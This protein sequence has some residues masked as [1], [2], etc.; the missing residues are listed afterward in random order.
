MPT[1]IFACPVCSESII[2][3]YN[4]GG[5]GFAITVKGEPGELLEERMAKSESAVEPNATHGET[6]AVT[7]VVVVRRQ[8]ND[9]RELEC[10]R[11][12][13]TGLHWD[14]IG[15]GVGARAPRPFL[16]GYISCDRIPDGSDFPHSCQHGAG[17]HRIKVVVVKKDN[18]RTMF[19]ALAAAAE[20]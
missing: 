13:I 20:Y 7:D 5:P 14:Q 15:G 2:L 1:D 12:D 17:P 10:R 11:E 19:A 8:W 4:E 18:D 9:W 16:H 3:A 6:R